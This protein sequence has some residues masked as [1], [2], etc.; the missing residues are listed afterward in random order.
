M[1]LFSNCHICFLIWMK[2]SASG[3]YVILLSRLLTGSLKIGIGKTVKSDVRKL[4][5]YTRELWNLQHFESTEK[6][7][8]KVCVLL[9]EARH[10]PSC[11]L[12]R[13]WV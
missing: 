2:F 8:E 11:L 10:L 7:L 9:H 4:I 3:L 6:S 12:Q 13:K 5:P 1:N